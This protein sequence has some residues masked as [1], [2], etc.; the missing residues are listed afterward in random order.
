MREKSTESLDLN[1][2]GSVRSG[3]ELGAFQSLVRGISGGPWTLFS[4]PFY[5]YTPTQSRHLKLLPPCIPTFCCSTLS[6]PEL[7]WCSNHRVKNMGVVSK[8]LGVGAEHNGWQGMGDETACS[9]FRR[10]TRR[11]CLINVF[12][13]LLR[14]WIRASNYALM[15]FK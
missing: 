12:I 3:A 15:G 4:S 9:L 14:A 2:L 8:D 5:M 1:P 7:I 11:L 10:I 6:Q 13:I